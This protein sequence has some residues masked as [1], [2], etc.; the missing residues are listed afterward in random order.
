[1][2]SNV[3]T[4]WC[5]RGKV[6]KEELKLKRL[7]LP[8]VIQRLG[9]GTF[10]GYGAFTADGHLYGWL[11]LEEGNLMSV[12]A[13]R[14]QELIGAEEAL[15]F[16][17]A[18]PGGDQERLHLYRMASGALDWLEALWRGRRLFANQQLCWLDIAALLAWWHE[19]GYNGLL[20]VRTPHS[21]SLV[22][23]ADSHVSGYLEDGWEDVQASAKEAY[24]S[25]RRAPALLD[26]I[27]WPDSWT[28]QPVIT[29]PVLQ[30]TWEQA[31]QA[32]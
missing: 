9:H 6:V 11:R 22:R 30:R 26:G 10:T 16:L 25:H 8:T 32:S 14:E 15:A 31:Q 5:P 18:L 28:P 12:W 19:Q 1:M 20:R 21:C 27:A 29:L 23:I 17:F 2:P 13:W 7:H 24:A 4:R 3:Q